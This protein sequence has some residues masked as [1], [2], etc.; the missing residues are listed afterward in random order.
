LPFIVTSWRRFG[1]TKPLAP[2]DSGVAAAG[3]MSPPR[4]G[5]AG[6]PSA[7][8]DTG[9]APARRSAALLVVSFGS[10]GTY[11]P[12]G[13]PTLPGQPLASRDK[14]SR[15]AMIAQVEAILRAIQMTVV[16]GR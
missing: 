9:L 1:A 16:A 2:T 13:S 3:W 8:A 4:R 15:R 5:R 10:A 11:L 14:A 7:N 12:L 6:S